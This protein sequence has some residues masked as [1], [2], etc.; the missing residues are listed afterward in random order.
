M[1]LV[2]RCWYWEKPNIRVPREP[3]H[4]AN[5]TSKGKRWEC[6]CNSLD[7]WEMQRV[8][9]KWLLRQTSGGGIETWPFR[10]TL[11]WL[12]KEIVDPC[13]EFNLY[14]VGWT[15][16]TPTASMNPILSL[17]LLVASR[18]KFTSSCSSWVISI[19]SMFRDPKTG[20]WVNSLTPSKRMLNLPC[21]VKK[22]GFWVPIAN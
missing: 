18:R 14:C 7:D 2:Y 17:V 15:Q 19:F 13:P 10:L 1:E 6:I 3:S 4:D 5:L 12:S 8:K 11:R 16:K 21:C 20:N 9:A 22:K